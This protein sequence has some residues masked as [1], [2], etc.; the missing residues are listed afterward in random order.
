[1]ARRVGQA[2]SAPEELFKKFDVTGDGALSQPEFE[3]MLLTQDPRMS[4]EDVMALWR[5]AD[6]DGNGQVDLYE[7]MSAL[8]RMQLEAELP[9]LT[10]TSSAPVA[11]RSRDRVVEVRVA[12]LISR[13]K[14][15]GL[16]LAQACGYF[17]Q[18]AS[19]FLDHAN[20]QRMLDWGQISIQPWEQEAIFAS[21]CDPTHPGFLNYNELARQNDF[22]AQAKT[23]GEAAMRA[24]SGPSNDAPAKAQQ[25]AAWMREHQVNLP[26]VFQFYDSNG[27][28]LLERTELTALL[29]A[30]DPGI[31][32]QLSHR[33][34]DLSASNGRV[35]FQD[36]TRSFGLSP[37]PPAPPMLASP[38]HWAA[39]PE[40]NS[41]FAAA[42]QSPAVQ[43][44]ASRV[45]SWLEPALLA[46]SMGVEGLGGAGRAG[47]ISRSD[48]ERLCLTLEPG[49]EAKELLRLFGAV[50]AAQ[51][52]PGHPLSDEATGL[53]PGLVRG[54]LASLRFSC[55]KLRCLL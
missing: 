9:G 22:A 18:Q 7:L 5:M 33:I 34:F 14:D 36:F 20:F 17:D 24:V 8:R 25:F 47:R 52:I 40:S 48:F 12:Q 39:A 49:L 51:A 45:Q 37:E 1:V 31:S 21:A 13:F 42:A 4:R 16:T 55:G 44:L 46:K 10:A 32:E 11:L 26:E 53:P 30:A 41:V 54:T 27:N 3:R 23:A 35:G 6:S 28:G 50:R 38:A 19:G 15:S 2:L 29:R 43:A